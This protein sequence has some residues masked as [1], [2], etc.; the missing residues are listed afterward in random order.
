MHRIDADAHVANMFDE[1]DP[2]VPLA[3]TQVDKHWLNAVQEEIAGAVVATGQTLVKGTW[4]QLAKA[5]GLDGGSGGARAFVASLAGELFNIVNT[6]LGNALKLAGSGTS[7]PVL[8]IQQNSTGPLVD[9]AGNSGGVLVDLENFGD[10]VT[11]R[12]TGKDGKSPLNLTPRPTLPISGMAAGDLVFLSGAYNKLYCY[13][14]T[15]WNSCW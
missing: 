5:I 14:G 12:L 6:G 1:G 2:G 15:T 9:G 3:P 4:D 10:G 7:E 13:D 8:V 11:L